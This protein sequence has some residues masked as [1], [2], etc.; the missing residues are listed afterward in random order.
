MGF[1]PQAQVLHVI[2]ALA[3]WPS[4]YSV[5]SAVTN[6]K[7]DPQEPITGTPFADDYKGGWKGKVVFVKKI[8]AFDETE[9]NQIY[10][11][12]NYG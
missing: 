3:K 9:R 7:L 6:V 11:V 10:K 2:Y 5:T 8:R 12:S 1:L 4:R